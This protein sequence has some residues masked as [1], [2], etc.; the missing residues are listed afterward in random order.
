[1]YGCSFSEIDV[2][3]QEQCRQFVEE[4]FWM[5]RSGS[6]WRSLPKEYG[7]GHTVYRRFSVLEKKPCGTRCCTI[8]RGM[9]GQL[10]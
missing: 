7:L 3:N 2:Q 1:M 4:V 10:Q 9:Q 8:F 6:Q 5:A